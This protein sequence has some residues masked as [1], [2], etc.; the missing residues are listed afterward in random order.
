MRPDVVSTK[1]VSGVERTIVMP[2]ADQDNFFE[3][4]NCDRCGEYLHV[5]TMSFFN[6]QTICMDCAAKESR[7]QVELK[8]RGKNPDMCEGCGEIPREVEK[9]VMDGIKSRK[10]GKKTE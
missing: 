1:I 6:F 3:T 2:G 9:I 5:R 4:W 10:G 7:A 8:V